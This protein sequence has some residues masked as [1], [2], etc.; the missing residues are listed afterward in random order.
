MRF[1]PWVLAFYN[2]LF[3]NKLEFSSLILYGFLK[4]LWGMVSSPRKPKVESKIR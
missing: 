2:M 4:P 3:M 1:L